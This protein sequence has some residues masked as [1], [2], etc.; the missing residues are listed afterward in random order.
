MPRPRKLR[1]VQSPPVVD[2]F[3]PNR[4]PPWGL[5]DV[6]LPIEG[7]EAVR[8]CDYEGLD[9]ESAARRMNVSRQTLGRVL[10][11][12]RSRIAE[13]LAMGRV[14]KIEGGHFETG[15][16]GRGRRHR[17]GRGSF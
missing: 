15:P 17:G 11:D 5:R 1:Y 9:Q 7:F 13:C 3:V 12:A 6:L 2:A 8:L 16:R 14:L 4:V 10:T